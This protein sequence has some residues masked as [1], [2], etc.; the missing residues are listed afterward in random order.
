[1]QSNREWISISDLMSGMM[2]FL[3]IAVV[4]MQKIHQDK[5]SLVED[6][7]KYGNTK[8]DLNKALHEEFDKDLVGWK[9]DILED[10]TIRFSNPK[11]TF[12]RS[13]AVLKEKFKKILYEFFP[14]YLKI[15][16]ADRFVNDI[17]ELRIEGHTSSIYRKN[18]SIESAYLYNAKL[19]QN[20]AFS[21]INYLF[22]LSS[23]NQYQEW[24]I[25]VFRSNGLA[26]AK[27]I[28]TADGVED[29]E[30]S[31]RVEFRVITNTEERIEAIFKKSESTVK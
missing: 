11:V 21:V 19:S 2:V 23:V 3:F 17:V 14:R 15:L 4:F 27:K 30:K 24:L 22:T 28:L 7:N 1:M 16:T 29:L 9:A 13:K 26:F 8:R 12:D 6:A 25:G 20:R 10:N 31:R 5:I 18:S